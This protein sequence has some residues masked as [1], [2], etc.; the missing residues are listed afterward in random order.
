M[1]VSAKSANELQALLQRDINRMTDSDRNTRKRGLQKLLDDIPW[2]PKSAE[3]VEVLHTFLS[4]VLLAPAVAVISDPVEK[5][6]ELALK[7]LMKIVSCNLNIEGSNIA[8]VINVLCGRVN[9]LPFPE[10]AEELRLMVLEV[11]FS[12]LRK[13]CNDTNYD[14]AFRSTMSTTVFPVI[15][16]VLQDNF[17]AVKV[18]GSEIVIFISEKFAR[19]V[20]EGFRPLLKS[21]IANIFHQHSKVRSTTL[22][23]LASSLLCVSEDF[24]VVMKDPILPVLLRLE[25]DRSAHTRRELAILCG[26]VLLGRANMAVERYQSRW[27]PMSSEYE[28]LA[29]LAMLCSDESD[30]V[31]VEAKKRVFDLSEMWQ[32]SQ[33]FGEMIVDIPLNADAV[34]EAV[35]G[36]GGAEAVLR[37]GVPKVPME[38]LSGTQGHMIRSFAGHLIE[39]YLDGASGW[40]SDS[41][42]RNIRAL[43]NLFLW[44]NDTDAL[45]LYNAD[46]EGNPNPIAESLP[47]ILSVLGPAVCTADV[48]IR[49]PAQNCCEMLGA[50]VM[51]EEALDLLLARVEGETSGTD[52]AVQRATAVLLLTS[53][54]KGFNRSLLVAPTDDHSKWLKRLTRA[55]ASIDLLEYRDLILREALVLLV[56]ALVNGY[57]KYLSDPIIQRDL[58]F[59]LLFICG[60]CAFESD[61][62]PDVA[63]TELVRLA[64]VSLNNQ[65][66]G[67][68]PK[69][70]A[71]HFSAILNLILATGILV[72]GN[73]PNEMV[74]IWIN[75][76]GHSARKAAFE[77]LIRE[78][79]AAAWAHSGL[80]LPVMCKLTRAKPRPAEDSEEAIAAKYNAMSGHETLT[81]EVD[82]RVSMIALM[83]GWIRAGALDWTCSSYIAEAA[84][85]VVKEIIMPNLVWKSGKVESTVRKVALVA[86]HSLLRAGSVSREVLFT[87]AGELVPAVVSNMDDS[88]AVPRQLCCFCLEIL[89]TRLKGA[90]GDDSIHQIYPKLLKRLDDSDDSIRKAVCKTFCSFLW[91]SD[92]KNYSSTTL[93]YSLDQLFLHLDDPDE[94]IQEVVLQVI[95]AVKGLNEALVLKKA[96]ANR[97]SHRSTI[98]CDRVV[99]SA[100]ILMQN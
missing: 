50:S 10:P 27:A 96:E 3:Q 23:A 53:M 1:T 31:Q 95:L 20:Q 25:A 92:V 39:L 9:D 99:Q 15:C 68:V 45:V 70:L 58:S 100:A 24:E 2:N 44:A 72:P 4:D 18:L 22:K 7:I 12:L 49:M 81:G 79:P 37:D 47:R 64:S 61:T 71:S 94:S 35:S 77:I 76:T 88:E 26:C 78:C 85:P 54:L 67:E 43:G 19:L 34:S 8:A 80:I 48:E 86:L 46:P 59:C 89:F 33:Q 38:A 73:G 36:L 32:R 75:W 87:V 30:E 57:A 17:P 66:A 52:T 60:R 63:R 97:L 98:M 90:F 41:K 84:N 91:C 13:A 21:L 83:E 11:L 5:C 55:V 56:R 40:T 16:K 42:L 14:T 82:I 6:R 51:P 65:S 69:M 93:E 28:L 29:I 74:P 62:V